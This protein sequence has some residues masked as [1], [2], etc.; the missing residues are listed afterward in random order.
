MADILQTNSI[1]FSWWN[2]LIKISIWF[3]PEG[4]IHDK[5]AL[6]KEMAWL[7]IVDKPISEVIRNCRSV[8]Y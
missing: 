8:I 6:A 1:E 2:I 5:S 4:A 7:Q 3:V